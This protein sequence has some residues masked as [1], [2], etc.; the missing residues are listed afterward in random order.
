MLVSC[1]EQCLGKMLRKGG[2]AQE[3]ELAM[4][5]EPRICCL[6]QLPGRNPPLRCALAALWLPPWLLQQPAAPPPCGLGKQP[7]QQVTEQGKRGVSKG[8]S[9]C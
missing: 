4:H 9:S 8:M 2:A 7:A 5:S 3:Q 6:H 1:P